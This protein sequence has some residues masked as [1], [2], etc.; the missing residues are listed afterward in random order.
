M[1]LFTFHKIVVTQVF[2]YKHITDTLRSVLDFSAF[3]VA[4]NKVVLLEPIV[5]AVYLDSHQNVV[6]ERPKKSKYNL[7]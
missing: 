1:R 2:P 4:Q 3:N 5:I 7:L 6:K